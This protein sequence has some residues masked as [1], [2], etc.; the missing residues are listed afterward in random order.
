MFYLI[1]LFPHQDS[2]TLIN[3]TM[4]YGDHLK[5]NVSPEYGV[6]YYLNYTALDDI[7]RKLSEEAPST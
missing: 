6:D 4:K 1:A 3:P 5:A 7:I 2:F